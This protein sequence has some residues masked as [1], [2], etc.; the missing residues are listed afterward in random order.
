MCFRFSKGQLPLICKQPDEV[1]PLTSMSSKTRYPT[2][3][4]ATAA[5]EPLDSRELSSKTT[6]GA[7]LDKR[8]LERLS[9]ILQEYQLLVYFT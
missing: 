3:M 9:G 1:G 4:A 6:M 5:P 7:F 8:A 2:H